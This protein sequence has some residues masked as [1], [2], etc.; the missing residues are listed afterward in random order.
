MGMSDKG[1]WE[2]ETSSSSKTCRTGYESETKIIRK[3]S[4]P[5]DQTGFIF[6]HSYFSRYLILSHF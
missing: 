4:I 6:V 2:L 5:F 3:Q 1:V